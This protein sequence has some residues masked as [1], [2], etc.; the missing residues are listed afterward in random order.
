MTHNPSLAM[1]LC[2]YFLIQMNAEYHLFAHKDPL[3]ARSVT[4]SQKYS[5]S[6]AAD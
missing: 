5:I 3:V 2:S 1:D 4:Y 6:I